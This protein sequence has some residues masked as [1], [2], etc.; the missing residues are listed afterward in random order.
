MMSL[1]WCQGGQ[2]SSDLRV[3]ANFILAD[4]IPSPLQGVVGKGGAPRGRAAKGGLAGR[5]R[6]ASI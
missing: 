6:V 5:A 4:R 3:R 2:H 1:S